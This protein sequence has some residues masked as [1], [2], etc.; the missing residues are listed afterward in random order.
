MRVCVCVRV[1]V[2]IGTIIMGPRT[3]SSSSS[4]S[5]IVNVRPMDKTNTEVHKCARILRSETQ[6]FQGEQDSLEYLE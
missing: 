5:W 1:C 4:S 6:D 3:S 2:G